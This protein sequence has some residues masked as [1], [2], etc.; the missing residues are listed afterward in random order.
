MENAWIDWLVKINNIQTLWEAQPTYL[1][2]Q[3]SYCLAALVTSIHAFKNGGRWPYLWLA[4]V[5]H[6]LFT[7]NFWSIALPEYDNFWH[8]TTPVMFLGSRL[9]LHIIFLYPTFIYHASYAV[10]KLNLP[11]YAEPFAAGLLV[12]LIDIPYDIVSVKFVHWTW[13]DT[14]PNIFDRHYWVP[15]NS[16]YFHA[17]FTASFY[18]IFHAS[19]RFFAPNEE[20][21]SSGKKSAEW[22][23][24][25]IS[26]L[27]GMPGGIL[28]FVTIYHPLHDIWNVHGEVTF[29]MLCSIFSL[30]V[31]IGLLNR[32]DKANEPLSFMDYVMVIQLSLHYAIYWIFVVFFSPE[33]ERS[34]GLHEPVGP[35]NELSS[36]VTAFGQTLY[37]RKY[38]CIDDYDEKYFDF[39]CTGAI[40]P[41]HGA[42]K[43]LICGTPFENRVEY[44]AVVST[45][46]IVAAGV[47]YGI[48]F[49]TTKSVKTTAI[50]VK[51]S[52]KKLN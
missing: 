40:R 32:S 29:F 15:W 43:Y 5:L 49:K 47:F 52:K 26:S 25:I 36:L 8:S 9:P 17:S 31:F 27:L 1:I 33:R 39:N 13:H 42:S 10:S 46:L 22:K 48:Y 3:A 20:K 34:Y 30:I 12:V 6:G 38:L 7:D 45:I 51:K 37:R 19:R 2:A 35:C 44:I 41:G 14:D 21:W 50:P 23:S 24:V 18:F 28:L 4:T 16:Y 11:S